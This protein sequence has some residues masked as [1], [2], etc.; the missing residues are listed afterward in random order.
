MVSNFQGLG[1]SGFGYTLHKLIAIHCPIQR[2]VFSFRPKIVHN[3]KAVSGKRHLE[4]ELR[5]VSHLELLIFP[6]LFSKKKKQKSQAYWQPPT[7]QPWAHHHS[8]VVAVQVYALATRPSTDV[9]T[10]PWVLAARGPLGQRFAL[11]PGDLQK[12]F[13]FN[14]CEN[15]TCGPTNVFDILL[16]LGRHHKIPIWRHSMNPLASA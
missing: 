13:H 11:S 3:L 2:L 8:P 7:S 15:E 16:I 9:A 10:T 4:C 5:K 6:R 14:F 1:S 12:Q